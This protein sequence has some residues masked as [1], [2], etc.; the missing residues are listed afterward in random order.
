[1][2][3]VG[4]TNRTHLFD[5]EDAIN[6]N[7]AMIQLVH[8][9]NYRISGFT[10]EVQIS[11]VKIPGEKFNIPVVEDI[12][13]GALIDFTK[14]GLPHEP[15]VQDS[16]KAGA[17][18]VTFS[19]DKILGGPQCGI[20]VG[21]KKYIDKIKKNP[22]CRALR[23]DKMTYS[24]L[25]ATL[26][27]F[28]DEKTLP[29]KHPVLNMLTLPVRTIE[30]RARRFTKKIHPLIEDVCETGVI[31]GESQMGSGS[32]PAKFIPTKLAALKPK[33]ISPEELG[34]RLRMGSTP[35][36]TRIA[37]NQVLLDF[38]TIRPNEVEILKEAVLKALGK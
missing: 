24:V 1:M 32:L 7:T 5:Y 29:E 38:R 6:E 36:F 34:S 26:K 9:S 20:I 33:K 10:K 16:V 2:I 14:Y 25:E 3:E 18:V 28:L 27:L 30:N 11:E 4:T 31:N 37:D 12:G 35:V 22:L 15:M 13:S 19:G 23:C 8:S 17:D 21:K